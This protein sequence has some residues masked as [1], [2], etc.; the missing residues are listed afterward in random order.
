MSENNVQYWVKCIAET[1]KR[2][3]R[4]EVRRLNTLVDD[5]KDEIEDL[6]MVIDRLKQENYG[7][8]HDVNSRNFK[9]AEL[10][11]CEM[12]NYKINHR[13]KKRN[14]NPRNNIY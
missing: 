13:C 10:N 11:N 3:A 2:K 9:I 14:Q 5:L 12:N 1:E 6:N 4:R 8:K 7:L